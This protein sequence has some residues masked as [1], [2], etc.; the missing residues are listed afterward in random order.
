MK[1]LNQ[2]KRS[3]SITQ[4]IAVAFIPLLLIFLGGFSIG[5]TSGLEQEHYE[6][7]FKEADKELRQLKKDIALQKRLFAA[8]DSILLA[9]DEERA[10][11]DK[12]ISA[13]L[14]E[15]PQDFDRN[16]LRKKG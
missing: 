1:I 12:S 11:L 7:K 8:G 10:K 4:F 3:T 15:N 16:Y 6:K 5:K 9:M 2:D 13:D 14:E